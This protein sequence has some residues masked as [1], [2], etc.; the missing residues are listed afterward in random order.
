[1][2]D[3]FSHLPPEIVTDVVNYISQDDCIECMQVCHRWHQT[4]PN[5]SQHL[6]QQLTIEKPWFD[7]EP[8]I[9]DL[10]GTK[11]N[12]CLMKCLPHVQ[13]VSIKGFVPNLILKTLANLT[14]TITFLGK[15]VR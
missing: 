8:V 9:H 2:P 15:Y 14:C 4:I 13:E 10:W 5:H 11:T 1:M 7:F 3:L 12:D 6:W